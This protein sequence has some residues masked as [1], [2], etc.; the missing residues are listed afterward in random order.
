MA[1]QNGEP[2]RKSKTT[3]AP[4]P[5][6]APTKPWKP[7]GRDISRPRADGQPSTQYGQN[8]A[9]VPSSIPPGTNM[10][11]DF[12]ISPKAGDNALD[13]VRRDGM[14]PN[15]YQTRTID[16][17]PYPTHPGMKAPA[18]PTKIGHALDRRK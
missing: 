1:F 13:I 6:P 16:T 2:T 17:K 8:Q 18:A 14:R 10:S 15:N 5:T 4:G 12:D 11:A 3:G 7:F 9:T